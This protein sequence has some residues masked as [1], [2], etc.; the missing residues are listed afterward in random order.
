MTAGDVQ[1]RLRDRLLRRKQHES[2]VGFTVR[3]WHDDLDGGYVVQCMELPGCMSQGETEAEALDNI[4]EAIGGVLVVMLEDR[5][6][7]EH[8]CVDKPLRVTER[9]LPV[10]V[11]VG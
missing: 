9:E 1:R 10:R 11:A 2:T 3:M 6:R 8:H 4:T 7:E 5:I